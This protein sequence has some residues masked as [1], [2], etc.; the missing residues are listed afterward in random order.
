MQRVELGFEQRQ[1][2]ALT[3][4]HH[5]IARL[6]RAARQLGS[7]PLRGLAAFEHF[8]GVLLHVAGL[9]ERVAPS[10]RGV[11]RR[12]GCIFVD[13]WQA[14]HAPHTGGAR[15]MGAKAHK[16]ALRLQ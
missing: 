4:Q 8:A 15:G 14:Q 2:F 1:A 9:G 10:G 13:A 12:A 16:I 3:R 7:Q 5:H 11:C 6:Q